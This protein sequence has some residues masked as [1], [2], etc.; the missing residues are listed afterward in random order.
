MRIKETPLKIRRLECS[1]LEKVLP[2]LLLF[3]F[4]IPAVATSAGP[5]AGTSGVPA[6][7][8]VGAESSCL[9]CHN[10]HALN[11][12]DDGVLEL[13]NLPEQYKPGQRYPLV[14]KLSHPEARRW[15]F[16][17]TAIAKQSYRGAGD[18]ASL[19]G[20]KS[21]QRISGG[22]RNYMQH[23]KKG[24]AATG[25]GSSLSYEWR[26]EWIAPD[27]NVGEVIFYG[28]GN[29]ANM[30]GSQGGDRIYGPVDGAL[31]RVPPAKN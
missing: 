25:V 7:F 22:N 23:G 10:S 8:G 18:F 29:A 26:F 15:G 14:L 2:G 12:D 5:P 21:T 9:Q 3:A 11:P 20:D 13:L 4:A 30:D 16:Q 28:L 1:R 6:G 19:D 24:R 27:N 17:L 31:G